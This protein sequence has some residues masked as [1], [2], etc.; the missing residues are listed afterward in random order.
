MENQPSDKKIWVPSK[1]LPDRVK[2]LALQLFIEEFKSQPNW[3]GTEKEYR[4]CL[5]AAQ[6]IYRIENEDIK[7]EGE[8][9]AS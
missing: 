9:K 3:E 7:D 4:R 6:I 5:E 2:N 8:E 1:K